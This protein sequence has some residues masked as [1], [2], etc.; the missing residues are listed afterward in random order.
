M[1]NVGM[2]LSHCSCGVTAA[3][4]TVVAPTD[5]IDFT[6]EIIE[7]IFHNLYKLTKVFISFMKG[8]KMHL[9]APLHAVKC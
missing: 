7:D 1:F 8:S 6:K 2:A 9:L 5:L 4:G 3:E